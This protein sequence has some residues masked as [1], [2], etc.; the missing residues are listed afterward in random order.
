MVAKFRVVDTSTTPFPA[1]DGRPAEIVHNLHLLDL[2]T[3]APMRQMPKLRLKT[4]EDIG[5]YSAG[6]LNNKDIVVAVREM[7]GKGNPFI[8]GEILEV[9]K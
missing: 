2:D 5:R 7:S 1:R 9:G 4:A 3:R 6:Q 8:V